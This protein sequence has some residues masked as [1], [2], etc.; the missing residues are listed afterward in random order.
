MIEDP[1]KR[2]ENFLAVQLLRAVSAWKEWGWG[3][4][5]LNFVRTKD[6]R[7]ADFLVTKDRKPWILVEAKVSDSTLDRNLLYFKEALGVKLA[8]Q[9]LLEGDLRKQITPGVFVTDV[10]RFLKL[11]V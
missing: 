5:S 3:D 11:L 7:E 4:F 6:G 2:F 1:G 10:G 9:V 8:F